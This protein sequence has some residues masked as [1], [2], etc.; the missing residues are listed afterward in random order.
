MRENL[1]SDPLRLHKKPGM[2]VCLCNPRA[3]GDWEGLDTGRSQGF[4]GQPGELER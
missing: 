1:S 3:G 2:T 4:A